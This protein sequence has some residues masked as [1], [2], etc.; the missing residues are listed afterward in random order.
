[1]VK[2]YGADE[3]I[4]HKSQDFTKLVKDVDVVIDLVGGETQAKSFVVVKKGGLLLSAV[5]PP[6]E[7][8]AK[9]YGIT[10]RFISSEASYK[11]LDFG[12][13]LV[14]DGK[15]KPQIAK[16]LTL[17]DAAEAQDLVS[18]GGLNGKVVLAV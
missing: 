14:E 9:Q 10:A 7:E 1:M 8:L 11:K 12:K 3:V 4:D 5:M 16:V 6:P 13:Q 18:A 2:S 15:I 17:E